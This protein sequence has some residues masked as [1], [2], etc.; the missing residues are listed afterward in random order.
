MRAR[1]SDGRGCEKMKSNVAPRKQRLISEG[2]SA[3]L[4]TLNAP[5]Y[6]PRGTHYLVEFAGEFRHADGY[7]MDRFN[8]LN[9]PKSQRPPA[10]DAGPYEI[11]TENCG[12]SAVSF[13]IYVP[14]NTAYT[15]M[16]MP[17]DTDPGCLLW[18]TSAAT[19]GTGCIVTGL[20]LLAGNG[21]VQ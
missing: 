9:C 17:I 7:M 4:A 8:V 6:A 13:Y 5:P 19:I 16:R 18:Y 3:L 2:R 12:D 11:E 20:L 14:H 10:W 21:S 1:A 15:R